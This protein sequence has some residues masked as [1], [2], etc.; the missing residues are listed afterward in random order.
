MPNSCAQYNDYF[1]TS[2][3]FTVKSL[4]QLYCDLTQGSDISEAGLKWGTPV[5]LTFWFSRSQIKVLWAIP[6]RMRDSLE[7]DI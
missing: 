1:T 5:A 6:F 7:K 4:E 3:W 2:F